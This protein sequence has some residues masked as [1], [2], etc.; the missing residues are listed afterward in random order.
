MRPT[1]DSQQG[2]ILTL[3][4]K[5]GAKGITSLDALRLE[6]VSRLAAVIHELR[7]T[8]GIPVESERVN[9]ET[10]HGTSNVSRYWLAGVR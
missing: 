9:V 2:R 6:G 1:F 8:Y 3:L 10:R 4:E 7:H 5:R